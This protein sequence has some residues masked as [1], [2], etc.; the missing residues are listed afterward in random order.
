MNVA[1]SQLKQDLGISI[2][3]L[4]WV[5]D[6]YTLSFAT[7]LLSAGKAGDITGPKKI[8]C[9][10]LLLFSVASLLCGIAHSLSF[11]VIARIL[12]GTGAALLVAN[13]L[14][15]I[16]G[17]FSQPPE[18]AKAFGIW[19]GVG[20]IAIAMGPV[21]G[22]ILISR[23][24]WQAAFF[25]NIPV[26][27]LSL[28]M[29][30]KYLPEIATVPRKI[31]PLAQLLIAVALASLAWAFITAG[32]DGWLSATVITS[33]LLCIAAITGFIFYEI[34]SEIPLLPRGIFR[35]K[36]FAAATSIG[37]IINSGFYGQL[38]IISLYFQQIKHYTTLHSGLALLPQAIIMAATA[39]C[40]GRI[41]A[42]TGPGIPVLAGLSVSFI[43]LLWLSLI[44]TNSSY[45]GVMIP[46]LLTGMGMSLT[47]PA[48]VAACMAEAP[49]GQGGI[50]SGIIN[51][52]RQSG[53][54]L[55]VAMAGSFM[56]DQNLSLHSMHLAL[57]ATL[58]FYLL[59]WCLA[60]R[61]LLPKSTFIPLPEP[62]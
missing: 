39:F 9:C 19:G 22:G 18:R 55:G 31:N 49:L 28:A 34:T 50:T 48:T 21:A 3:G 13:S 62:E 23:F 32:Y 7:L 26:G 2:S 61:W 37:L 36:K 29:A 57:L 35:I 60:L 41:I 38:F 33:G 27:V 14:S 46:M 56:G 15:L 5:I 10:G 45:I 42:R 44:P 24:G 16:Q 8:F 4:Q 52:A 1:L 43:G 54:V 59:A 58:P 11:L 6:A 47:A 53:S 17:I 12:Q 25:L 20:G 51:T 30:L 40:C